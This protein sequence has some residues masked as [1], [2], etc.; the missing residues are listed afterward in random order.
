[1]AALADPVIDLLRGSDRDRYLSTLYAPPDR[2]AALSSLFAFNA[3]IAGIRGRVREPLAGEIR[4]QWWRDTIA[5]AEPGRQVGNPLADA[6]CD[7]II[8][9]ELPRQAF[10]NLVEARIFDLY[11]DPMPSRTDLEG[12]CGETEGAII[13]LAAM[14][15]DPKAAPDVAALAGHAGCALA[16]A[17]MLA[18]LP[19]HRARG[20]CYVPRDLLAAAGTTP[21]AFVGG[22]DEAAAGRAVEAMAALAR[23]HLAAFRNGSREMPASLRPAFLPVALI[24][25]YLA[26][27][28]AR[29]LGRDAPIAG[30]AE[31][32]RQWRLLGAAL[33][34]W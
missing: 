22:A 6:L 31:W 24:P 16:I 9:H 13:Q 4:M 5:A 34:R 15:L 26:S 8:H 25:A 20:Q 7:A 12:Y 30:I 33:G 23:E 27:V 17:G 21:E 19:L 14:V 3:E 28:R 1:M 29:G 11:D 2:R 32:R 10:D 18:R